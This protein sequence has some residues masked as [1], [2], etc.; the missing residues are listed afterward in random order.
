MGC[1]KTTVGRQLAQALQRSFF[2]MDELIEQSA[3]TSVAQL[4]TDVGEASFRR[5][6]YDLM[7][8]LIPSMRP[9][10][11]A[12]GGGL[13]CTPFAMT[14]LNRYS[15]TVYLHAPVDALCA[16][17]AHGV[18]QRPLLHGRER[19]R[20][21]VAALLSQRAPFYEQAQRVVHTEGLSV[22]EVCGRLRQFV[23]VG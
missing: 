19:L 17:L 18:A 16:R 10:V 21:Y 13:P 14:Y 4:F 2:D 20:E 9:S 1:G 5:Y 23:T 12:C 7:E 8:R 6:E 15:T 3:G 22:A 11:V